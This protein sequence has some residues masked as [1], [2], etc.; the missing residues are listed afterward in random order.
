MPAETRNQC[1]PYNV[2]KLDD[3][4]V[5][6][7]P[8]EM[9]VPTMETVATQT[10]HT[11]SEGWIVQ[12]SICSSSIVPR[13]SAQDDWRIKLETPY[14][15]ELPQ[16]QSSTGTITNGVNSHAQDVC[17]ETSPPCTESVQRSFDT[18]VY[19]L[20]RS[21]AAMRRPN[22]GL[23]PEGHLRT[24]HIAN[25]S[26]EIPV[27][28]MDDISCGF[29]TP[30]NGDILHLNETPSS[31]NGVGDAELP[32]RVAL[33]PNVVEVNTLGYAV[34]RRSPQDK[35]I[36][37]SGVFNHVLENAHLQNNQQVRRCNFHQL[38]LER[39]QLVINEGMQCFVEP[40]H[41]MLL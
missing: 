16:C 14:H 1:E 36:P 11:H 29:T 25:M 7:F 3:F 22:I 30:R 31:F 12:C 5:F 38:S 34:E 33:P 17:V 35:T 28:R 2:M 41:G 23:G 9:E 4:P 18:A 8:I 37:V 40:C 32:R 20:E 24:T 26:R 10:D 19:R 13:A 6:I 21:A 27:S 39:K 15:G